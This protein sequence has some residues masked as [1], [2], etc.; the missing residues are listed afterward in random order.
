M[1]AS[2]AG[3]RPD[4][5][6]DDRARS[7][8]HEHQHMYQAISTPFGFFCNALRFVQ[9]L[10]TRDILIILRSG[11]VQLKMPLWPHL[12]KGSKVIG[13][14]LGPLTVWLDA[15][16]FLTYEQ[17]SLAAYESLAYANPV[18]RGANMSSIFQ[19]LQAGVGRYLLGRQ[20]DNQQLID[21]LKNESL[22]EPE[23]WHQEDRNAFAEVALA[24]NGF[25]RQFALPM[26]LESG[27]RAVEMW[28]ESF[29]SFERLYA[30]RHRDLNYL[31]PIANTASTLRSRSLPEI[32]ATHLA[33]CD[34]SLAAPIMPDRVFV[35]HGLRVDEMLP[36]RRYF[37]ILHALKAVGALRSPDDY[38][39]FT[40][41]VCEQLRWTRPEE[42]YVPNDVS[43]SLARTLGTRGELF[44]LASELR[45]AVPALYVTPS[46]SYEPDVE[47]VFKDHFVFNVLQFT[48][49]TFHHPN[50]TRL[51]S[52][53]INFV[54]NEWLHGVMV[55]VPKTVTLQWDAQPAELA[56]LRREA[57]EAI[58]ATLGWRVPPPP[59]VS[60]LA[61]TTPS[62]APA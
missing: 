26:V 1:F 2:L 20:G 6:L 4:A 8:V 13:S 46:I 19:R 57:Q 38:S 54:I 53:K 17:G 33:V 45:I 16:L 29:E 47:R 56:F 7:W 61:T 37:R 18:T 35:R 3:S 43:Q 23:K 59:I 42:V 12:C 40:D 44:R 51:D 21:A 60:A 27:S 41:A 25:D 24:V 55:G 11:G 48:D 9:T 36:Q 5:P 50:R 49:R 10:A 32:L 34:L 58:S 39:A 30:A 22:V 52:S 15:E 28:G 31:W 14:I 62:A